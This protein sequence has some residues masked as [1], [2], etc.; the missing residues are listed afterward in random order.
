MARQQLT[1]PGL[2]RREPEPLPRAKR[3]FGAAEFERALERNGFRR[4]GDLAFEDRE[5]HRLVRVSEI[6]RD[7]IRIA[8]RA[9]LAQLLRFRADVYRELAKLTRRT[10]QGRPKLRQNGPS[11]SLDGDQNLRLV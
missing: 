10:G 8:R 7:P 11:E 4:V 3:D 5:T 2:R 9:T 1:L 6:R